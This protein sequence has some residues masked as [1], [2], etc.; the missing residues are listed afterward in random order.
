MVYVGGNLSEWH[1]DCSA[2]RVSKPRYPKAN[3]ILRCCG[4]ILYVSYDCFLMMSCSNF[5]LGK[6]KSL[7]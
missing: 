1:K 5:E 2:S 4:F 3:R 6:Q 7:T